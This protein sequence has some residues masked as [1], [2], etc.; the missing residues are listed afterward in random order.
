MKRDPSIY[1]QHIQQ[2]IGKIQSYTIGM[3][4]EE[5]AVDDKT[6][7]AVF[8]QM[9]IIGEAANKFGKENQKHM[10]TVPWSNIIGMR[11]I[12]THDYESVGLERVWNAIEHHLTPLNEAITQYL[13]EHPPQ[14]PMSDE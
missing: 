7:D 6:Q 5:L 8:R 13:Q 12:I 3:T 10:P 4:Y 1:L 14:F 9:T 2:A 11:N